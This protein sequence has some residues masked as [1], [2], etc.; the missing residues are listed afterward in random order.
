MEKVKY[1][2]Y[3]LGIIN[4]GKRTLLIKKNRP[5]WQKGFYNAIGG[6]IEPNETPLEAIKRETEEECGLVISNWIKATK[7]VHFNGGVIY[8][9]KALISPEEIIKFKSITD[10]EVN[11]FNKKELDNIN[12]IDDLI[13]NI[14]S[15]TLI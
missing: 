1:Q 11:I 5:E 13:Y 7:E 15:E 9:F 6:K 3:V 14:L 10:E 4:D 12:I 2:E 8:I